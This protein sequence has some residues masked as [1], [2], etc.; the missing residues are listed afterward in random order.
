MDDTEFLD[1]F[2]KGTLPSSEFRHRGRLRLAWLVLSRHSPDE[3]A[4]ILTREIKRFATAQGQEIGIM[5][6]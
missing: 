6:R 3:S 5:R 2:H 1:A 4:S